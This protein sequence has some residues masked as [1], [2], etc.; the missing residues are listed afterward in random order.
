[1]NPEAPAAGDYF[2]RLGALFFFLLP[3]IWVSFVLMVLLHEVIGHG[4][5]ALLVG[6]RFEGFVIHWRGGGYANAFPPEDAPPLSRALL[7]GG[8]IAVNFLAGAASL[9]VAL[10][11]RKKLFLRLGL[12][13]FAAAALLPAATYG[14]VNSLWPDRGG[15]V[16]MLLEIAG[17]PWVRWTVFGF[18]VV[19]YPTLVIAI[20]ALFFQ[21]AEDWLGAGRR[22]ASWRRA[23][24]LAALA[25]LAIAASMSN[26]WEAVIPGHGRTISIIGAAFEVLVLDGLYRF[27]LRPRAIDLPLRAAW[28][29]VAC[30][31][32]AAALVLL[33]SAT[34]RPKL[35]FERPERLESLPIP[36]PNGYDELLA[37]G[38]AIPEGPPEEKEEIL[39]GAASA[40]DRA[41]RA[42]ELPCVVPLLPGKDTFDTEL[43]AIRGLGK[44]FLL[45]GRLAESRGDCEA[46]A[47]SYLD[48]LRL[49]AAS[50]RGGLRIHRVVGDELESLGVQGLAGIAPK[51]SPE[52]CA[53]AARTIRALE[54]DRE[55][56]AA[57]VRRDA[58]HASQPRWDELFSIEFGSLSLAEK[59][60]QRMTDDRA[61]RMAFAAE[62]EIMSSTTEPAS[63]RK[64][65]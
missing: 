53:S 52:S 11:I 24:P 4:C 1:M 27:S 65:R 39:P 50:T 63:G 30:A 17:R 54:I 12:L 2:R 46:A 59:A 58:G 29:P 15:D 10:S 64:A 61:R 36:V 32:G 49:A 51:L 20:N 28:L 48:L 55:D 45:E 8:G 44:L 14:L 47:R 35:P 37:A 19:L 40:L 41:R 56:P 21:I 33:A 5:T 7:Y 9:A 22:L 6:G 43:T 42:L 13:L 62:L 18:F 16:G 23:A 38:G 34:L 31:A 26:S 60:I 25:A 3:S 57:I